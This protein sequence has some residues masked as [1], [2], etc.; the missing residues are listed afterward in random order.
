MVTIWYNA[1]DPQPIAEVRCECGDII[2][3]PIST[4]TLLVFK[5]NDVK[6]KKFND[7]FD[8]LTEEMIEAWDIESELQELNQDRILREPNGSRS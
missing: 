2:T 7:K 1:D 4:E 5:S 3:Y 6:I 8:P